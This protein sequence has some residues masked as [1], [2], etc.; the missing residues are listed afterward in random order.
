MRAQAPLTIG[1]QVYSNMML[2]YPNP[3]FILGLG[4]QRALY[5]LPGQIG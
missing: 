2:E 5:F 3:F 4:D 1:D